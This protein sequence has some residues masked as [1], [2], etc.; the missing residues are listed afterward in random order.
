[1]QCFG[2]KELGHIK[3]DCPKE[4]GKQRESRAKIDDDPTNKKTKDEHSSDLDF[5]LLSALS[6]T[7]QISRDT[8]FIDSGASHHMT[9]Y[10]DHLANVVQREFQEKVVLGDDARYAVKGAGATSFQLDSRKTLRMR[11]VLLVPL[12]TSNLIVVSALEHEGYD[13][14]FSRG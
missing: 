10:G 11:G 2:C 6:G 1:M 12:M 9:N 8:W 4:K 5:L 7:V 14:I 3:R 13:V